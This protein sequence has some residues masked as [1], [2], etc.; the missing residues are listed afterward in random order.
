MDESL[1]F[2]AAF[3]NRHPDAA[4][5]ALRVLPDRDVAALLEALPAGAAARAL[6]CMGPLRAAAIVRGMGTETAARILRTTS[7]D[8]AAALLRLFDAGPREALLEELPELARQ[9]VADSLEYPPDSVGALMSRSIIA[10]DS[11]TRVADA[12]AELRATGPGGVECVFVTDSGHRVA[13]LI[14]PS[15]ILRSKPGTVLEHLIDASPPL[16]RS[17]TGLAA[18][19]EHE[20]WLKFD[21]LPV[22]NRDRQLIGALTHVGLRR[23]LDDPGSAARPPSSSILLSMSE[24]LVD[25]VSGLWGLLLDIPAASGRP[26][27]KGQ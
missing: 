3:I 9:L 27:G 17:R 14:S 24:D 4:A 12:L 10:L 15:T 1:E 2:S 25:S 26:T 7:S 16:L 22:V 20:A 6:E 19:V 11:G 18:L 5:R 23:W 13:G 21:V 8:G